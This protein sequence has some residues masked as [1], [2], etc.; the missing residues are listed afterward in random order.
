MSFFRQF[1]CVFEAVFASKP[2]PTF[3]MR[4]L[5][6]AGLLAKGPSLT[7]KISQQTGC[8]ASNTTRN[9]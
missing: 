1:L 4:S 3:G 5:V 8:F 2:A 6:G 9:K 7:P